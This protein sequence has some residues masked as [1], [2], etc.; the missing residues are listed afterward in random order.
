V[1]LAC[2]A[3]MVPWWVV[4]FAVVVA[5][6]ATV[7]VMHGLHTS[8]G[9]GRHSG[10]VLADTVAQ[11]SRARTEAH[12]EGYMEGLQARQTASPAA[13]LGWDEITE[14]IPIQ[15]PGCLP[16]PVQIAYVRRPPASGGRFR[17]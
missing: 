9:Y 8:A 11:L 16:W 12:H 7:G 17:E 3:R 14:P 1:V 6:L 5:V 4:F 15:G 13:G 10:G 2:V